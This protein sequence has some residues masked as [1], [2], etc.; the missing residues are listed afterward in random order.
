MNKQRLNFKENLKNLEEKL[1]NLHKMSVFSFLIAGQSTGKRIDIC[2][3]V[4]VRSAS[5]DRKILRHN[6]LYYQQLTDIQKE[7][8]TSMSPGHYF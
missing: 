6:Q 2:I 7:E 1:T 3:P 8:K 5:A 4:Q